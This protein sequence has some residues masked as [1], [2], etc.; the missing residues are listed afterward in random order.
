M[1]WALSKQDLLKSGVLCV[2]GS[3][4]LHHAASHSQP[5]PPQGSGRGARPG[6]GPNPQDHRWGQASSLPWLEGGLVYKSFEKLGSWQCH[7]CSH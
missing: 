4:G 1:V 7:S 3:A 2:M 5:L 6:G